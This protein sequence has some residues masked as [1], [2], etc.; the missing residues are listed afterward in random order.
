MF[1][2]TLLFAL[3]FSVGGAQ[4][5]LTCLRTEDVLTPSPPPPPNPRIQQGAPGKQGPMGLKGDNGLR[6]PKGEPGVLD[7]SSI[8]TLKS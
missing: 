4:E 1:D 3:L 5:H 2:R 7:N 6:G 8:E